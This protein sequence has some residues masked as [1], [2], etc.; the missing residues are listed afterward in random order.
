MSPEDRSDLVSLK[1]ALEANKEMNV[2]I[3]ILDVG[4]V[5]FRTTHEEGY[6]FFVDPSIVG[7][8]WA[9]KK[10]LGGGNRSAFVDIVKKLVE[11]SRGSLLTPTFI[12]SL[13]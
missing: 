8:F 1:L 10:R 5:K 2:L 13:R 11:N 12:A 9:D 6:Y 3:D 7:V 4:A